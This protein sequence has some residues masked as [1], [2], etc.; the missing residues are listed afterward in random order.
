M[1]AALLAG[2]AFADDGAPSHRWSA[3][4]YAGPST[5][6]Y[7]GAALQNL[8]FEPTGVMIGLAADR[9]FLNLGWEVALSGEVQVTQYLFGHRDTSFA[10][11]LGFQADAPFGISGTILSF[12]DGPSYAL[13]PPYT[14][15]GYS[16]H[17]WPSWRKKF[18]NYLS[19]EY[20]VALSQDRKWD[21]VFRVYH[22]SGA[23]GLV[24]EGDDD[25][26]AVG[27]GIRRNF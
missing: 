3:S 27:L 20:A 23:F 8:N 21:G 5:T 14:S 24:S 1:C 19:I 6:K 26:L 15:I 4:L 2:P 12:Y 10:A 7:F 25:G 16:G 13:D 11:G 22:R 17:V 18:L 9:P